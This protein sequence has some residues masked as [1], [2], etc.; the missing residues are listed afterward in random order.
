[1][2]FWTVTLFIILAVHQNVV[3]LQLHDEY[4]FES[5]PFTFYLKVW[6][7]ILAEMFFW[8]GSICNWTNQH[9]NKYFVKI[10]FFKWSPEV[11]HSWPS[12]NNGFP[13]VCVYVFGHY[14]CSIQLLLID[15]DQV[16]NSAEYSANLLLK[17]WWIATI[18]PLP[19]FFVFFRFFFFFSYLSHSPVSD[20]HNKL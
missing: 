11:W 5:Q 9:I 13:A 17:T 18:C 19:D 6:M 20:H 16:I 14:C 7:K 12:P 15:S 2:C 4:E 10:L 3:K 8:T 1:M